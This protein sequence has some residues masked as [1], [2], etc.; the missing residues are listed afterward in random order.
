MNAAFLMR[1]AVAMLF[2]GFAAHV[3]SPL[4]GQARQ[5]ASQKSPSPPASTPTPR[6]VSSL[7]P[8]PLTSE[9]RDSS[10]PISAVVEKESFSQLTLFLFGSGLALFIALLGWSDQIRGIDR[11]TK[12]LE[13]QF[14]EKTGIDKRS[15]LNI[16]KPESD[17][18][19]AEALTQ[20]EALTQVVQAGL[21]NTPEKKELL[22]TF[23]TSWK[24]QLAWIETLSA[25]KYN[26]TIALTV[27]L[28][29]GGI[30][31]LYT[32]PTQQVHLFAI[33]AKSELLVLLLPI[34]LIMLLLVIIVLS[35]QREKALRS[36]LN[37]IS[38]KL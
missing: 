6:Q 11:D 31:S 36:L 38:D 34:T 32:S 4:V 7:K 22:R 24:S 35:V 1:A 19:Q 20:L 18:E 37:S 9:K 17:N 30:A 12:E 15:F 27:T 21:L 16:V 28:F 13:H 33:T 14:L 25:W 10:G 23:A 26:L 5:P 3:Q 29:I 2:I 8:E